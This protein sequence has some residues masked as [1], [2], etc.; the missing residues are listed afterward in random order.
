M[1]RLRRSKPSADV[2]VSTPTSPTELV[3]N[4]TSLPQ[5]DSRALV[6]SSTAVA[7]SVASA[8]YDTRDTSGDEFAVRRGDTG[9]ETAYSAARMAVEIAKESSDLF[10]PLKAVAGAMSILIKNYDVSVS[11]H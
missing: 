1:P 4:L 11:C 9:W 7:L 5:G 6:A 2:S 10:L 8:F 3:R